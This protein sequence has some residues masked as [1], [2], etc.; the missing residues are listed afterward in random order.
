MELGSVKYSVVLNIDP[1]TGSW[2]RANG[3]TVCIS[4]PDNLRDLLFAWKL[5][6]MVDRDI[7]S[8]GFQHQHTRPCSRVGFGMQQ[9]SYLV[10][11]D[12]SVFL[13]RLSQPNTFKRAFETFRKWYQTSSKGGHTAV[14][15]VKLLGLLRRSRS[16]YPKL[17][18]RIACF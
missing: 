7:W 1:Y 2:T 16:I 14:P 18:L 12:T 11:L 5:Q 3:D 6:Y 9:V 8:L 13:L 10:R 17:L 4:M 15:I